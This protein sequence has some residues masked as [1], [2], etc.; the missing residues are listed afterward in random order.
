MAAAGWRHERKE[1]SQRAVRVMRR[2]PSP[3]PQR[4]GPTGG[5]LA[6]RIS[7]VSALHATIATAPA[8]C[9]P[10]RAIIVRLDSAEH[11]AAEDWA[12][13]ASRRRGGGVGLLAVLLAAVILTVIA[14]ASAV[15]FLSEV[16]ILPCE[17]HERR[18]GSG[19]EKSLGLT[20][21][22]FE[23]ATGLRAAAR[24]KAAPE[25]KPGTIIEV[26]KCRV[27]KD[28]DVVAYVATR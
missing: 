2:Q 22:E 20:V 27:P 8:L 7:A 17:Y 13:M 18:E 1:Q 11:D 15:A 6:S 23:R 5:P 14:I 4:L 12:M 9:Q 10:L 28:A 16:S 25:A 21:D 24:L 26:S 3:I 19:F